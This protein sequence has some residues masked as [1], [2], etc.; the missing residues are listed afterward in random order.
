MAEMIQTLRLTIDV[1]SPLHIGS[2]RT[3]QQGYDFVV[4]GDRT[5]RI[6]EDAFFDSL[7][8]GDAAFDATLLGR[9]AEELLTDADY[10]PGS[11]LFRYVMPGAPAAK[12]RGAEVAEQIKDAHDRPY[13]PGS[14]L[15]GALRTLLFWGMHAGEKRPPDLNRLGRSR[16]GAAQSLERELFG[17]DPNHDW[18][19]ALRVRDSRPA[20]P[21]DALALTNV[22]VY[23][24]ESARSSGLDIDVEAVTPGTRFE[25]EIA[26]ENFGFTD[27]QAAALGWQGQRRWIKSLPLLSKYRARSR[28]M[29]EAEYFMQP[30]RPTGAKAFYDDLINRL[31]S[32]PDDTLLL[33]IGWGAGWESKTLGSEML[34]RDDRQFER[35]LND[36][37]MTKQRRREPGDPFPISRHLA[38]RGGRP[39]LP[40]GWLQLRIAGLDAIE[41]SEV[42]AREQPA[43]RNERASRSGGALTGTVSRFIEDRGFGFIKPDG[44]GADVFM[45][46]SAIVGPA[47]TPKPGDR[48]SY[49]MEQGPKGPR[50]TNVRFVN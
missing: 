48:I 15:K 25:A 34:R 19:R 10:V 38:L 8:S 31:I 2:G 6:D 16:S 30:N 12:S 28:L 21:P 50:A 36:Y 45:H 41:V 4:H 11:E 23:P 33:Q 40:M 37:R 14:S 22:R 43:S 27:P 5:W 47:R 39:A 1:L 18:L 7:Q 46:V 44:G 9:P 35:L 24:T 20:D 42:P 29:V 26:L 49:D 13:L 32:L 17:K 3:L